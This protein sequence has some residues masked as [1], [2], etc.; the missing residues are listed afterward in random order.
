MTGDTIE[1][2]IE[3]KTNTGVVSSTFSGTAEEVLRA[4]VRFLSE[5][6][7]AFSMVHRIL[8]TVPS[9]EQLVDLLG[10]DVKI[11]GKDIVLLKKPSDAAEGIRKVLIAARICFELG[12]TDT[13]ALSVKELSKITSIIEKTINNNLTDL[14]KTGGVERVSKGTYKITDRGLLGTYAISSKAGARQ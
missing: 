11:A 4:A 1:A 2:L 6:L 12:V 9:A 7:P 3:I 14:V 5:S 8:L 13:S 10:D